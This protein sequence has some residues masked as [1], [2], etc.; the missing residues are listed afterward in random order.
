MYFF[1]YDTS[2]VDPGN[3]FATIMEGQGIEIVSSATSNRANAKGK[4][5]ILNDTD[6]CAGRYPRYY[7]KNTIYPP[8][9]PGTESVLPKSP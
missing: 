9:R 6:V 7:C 3:K 2:K 8:P 4:R 1:A 5:T